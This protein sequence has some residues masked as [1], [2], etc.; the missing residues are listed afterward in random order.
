MGADEGGDMV[1][2]GVRARLP[3]G[4]A[5]PC[6]DQIG[7]ASPARTG[8]AVF[9][10]VNRR[11]LATDPEHRSSAPN[12]RPATQLQCPARARRDEDGDR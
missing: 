6:P 2:A 4:Q 3:T 12:V 9:C 10:A 7:R 5:S 8:G 11:T 1:C